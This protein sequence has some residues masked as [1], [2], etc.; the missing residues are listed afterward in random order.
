[1][2]GLCMKGE[3][4]EFLHQFDLERMPLCRHG[5]RCKT[6]DCPFRHIKEEDRMECVFYK[7]GFCIHGGF[8]RYKHTRK[9][10]IDRALVCDF[11][12]GLSQMQAGKDG[13]AMRRPATQ[14]SEYFKVSMC[15]HFL[16]G[17]CPFGDG[18]HFAHGQEEL[19]RHKAMNP[20]FGGGGGMMSGLDASGEIRLDVFGQG[21]HDSSLD[22]FDG[23]NVEGGLPNP[24]IEPRSA[25]YLMGNSASYR[26]LAVIVGRGETWVGE[27]FAEVMDGLIKESKTGQLVIFFTVVSSGH[28]QAVGLVQGVKLDDSVKAKGHSKCCRVSMKFYRSMELPIGVAEREANDDIQTAGKGR[29]QEGF[30]KLTP[31]VGELVLGSCWNTPQATLHEPTYLCQ[32]PSALKDTLN[33]F[34]TPYLEDG[35]GWPIHQVPGFL[36]GATMAA[37]GESIEKGIF[38][39]PM[40]MKLAASKLQPGAA[41]FLFNIS[42]G[43]LFGIFEAVGRAEMNLDPKLF[44]KNPNSTSSP[45]PVQIK[46]RVCLEAPPLDGTDIILR[47]LFRERG[48]IP[49]VGPLSYSQCK[50]LADLITERCGAKAYMEKRTK[51][52]VKNAVKNGMDIPIT[53]PPEYVV[54]EIKQIKG[55][56]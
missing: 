3:R 13:V 20:K 4:C 12:L 35:D 48:G 29:G 42:D 27:E 52:G 46:V 56:R 50:T 7:Q 22:Y 37:M 28:I 25:I 9:E 31:Q 5:D 51:L 33:P 43:L 53:V 6:P 38:G 45:F 15:K 8:C 14:V 2:K 17:S 16:Q 24:V 11:T 1:M 44:S 41:L 36:F 18:C 19:Q 30:V 55:E 21:Y 40:H 26:D 49:K 32:D 23:R 10:R 39:L 34:F 47:Q 54:E